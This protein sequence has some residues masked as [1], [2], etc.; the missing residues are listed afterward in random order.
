[1]YIKTERLVLQPIGEADLDS[2]MKLLTDNIV[3]Q[4]YLLP[5]FPDLE[6]A[7]AMA[8]RIRALSQDAGRY[9]VGIYLDGRLVGLLNETEVSG[10][11]IEVGY[12]LLPQFYNQG[13]C[14]EALR[15][16]MAY[17]FANGF[18][19]VK[20]GAFENNCASIRVMEK[21]GMIKID[22]WDELEYRGKIHRC[23]YYA[24]RKARGG[25]AL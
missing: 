14:T 6:A 23:V 5:D 22:H 7:H 12:A 1:M 10:T 11:E 24:A 18:T 4:T 9:V 21:S 2:L 16:A 15:G 8:Q 20:A 19:Q 17:L 25:E 3:K 13:Y